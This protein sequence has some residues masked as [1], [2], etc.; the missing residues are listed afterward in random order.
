MKEHFPFTSEIDLLRQS[1]PVNHPLF[2]DEE[3][4]DMFQGQYLGRRAVATT[5]VGQ[6]YGQLHMI[7]SQD[8]DIYLNQNILCNK[9]CG[10]I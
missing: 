8:K 10:S 7:N 4:C 3:I 5:I 6:S 1:E 2:E 9:G